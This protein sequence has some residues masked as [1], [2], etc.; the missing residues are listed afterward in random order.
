[1]AKNIEET[2]LSTKT[3]DETELSQVSQA[4]LTSQAI[5]EVQGALILAKRFPRD[6]DVSYEKLM[7]SCKRSRFAE[8]ANYSFPRGGYQITGPSI[9][10]ARESARVWGNIEYGHIIVSDDDEERHI[11]AWAWDKETNARVF[12]EDSFKKLIYRKNQGWIKPDERDLRELTN[13][14]AAICKRNCI[15]QL[16]PRD[17]IEDAQD[18]CKQTIAKKV[19]EDPDKAKK[20]IIKAFSML[21]VSP[22]MLE[23]YLKHPV[24]QCSPTEIV[25][26]RE[27]YQSISD[28]NS[29]WSEYL[30]GNGEEEKPKN[31]GQLSMNALKKGKVDKTDESNEEVQIDANLQEWNETYNFYFKKALE[32]LSIK[33]EWTKLNLTQKKEL[34]E[35]V[36]KISLEP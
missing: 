31:E 11:R 23:E 2:A 18:V 16:M 4:N 27:I 30:N 5:S 7:R 35:E 3:S 9:N 24:S 6:E 28:G 8:K 21:N 20:D 1:M 13:R 29:K 22:I 10:L 19:S 14:R 25:D 15:L 12:E 26:L 33:K 32:N 17:F 34:L 36:K